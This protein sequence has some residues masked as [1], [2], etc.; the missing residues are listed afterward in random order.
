MRGTIERVRLVRTKLSFS[1]DSSANHSPPPPVVVAQLAA[2]PPQIHL[3]DVETRLNMHQFNGL[4]ESSAPERYQQQQQQLQHVQNGNGSDENL[5]DPT[6]TRNHPAPST[7]PN[8]E[9]LPGPEWSSAVGHAMT[10]KSGRVIH[11]LQ[12]DIARLTRECSLHRSRAE[13]AQRINETLKLQLQNV[14][15]RLRNSEQSHEAHLISIARKDRKIEDLKAEVRG[16]KDRRLKAEED[17]RRTN[18]LVAE[19][20]DESHRVLAEAS[21]IANYS[22]NQYETLTRARAKEQLEFKM[23]LDCF[24]AELKELRSREIERQ[25]QLT[26]FDVIM[27]QKNKEIEAERERMER[28]GRLFAEYKEASDRGIRELLE[29]CRQ[30]NAAIDDVVDQAKETT[31]RMRW[32]MKVKDE[33]RGAE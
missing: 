10:G 14:T 19:E 18:Q 21:E 11:N 16:E 4:F 25:N 15:D 6:T 9:S 1:R 26:R 13:E 20:R 31:G 28:F 33:V 8:G 12:E 3:P 27:E 22:R 30:N 29:K 23:R 17:A 24:R 5:H 2:E 32:V 7:M